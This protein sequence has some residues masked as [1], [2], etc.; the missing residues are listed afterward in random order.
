MTA[1]LWM[2]VGEST[3]VIAFHSAFDILLAAF[4]GL[5]KTKAT[6]QGFTGQL[7]KY[8]SQLREVI[9]PHLRKLTKSKLEK[10]WKIG[11]WI[12]IAADGTREAVARNKEL[13]KTF[14]PSKKN[15]KKRS[16]S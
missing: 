11:K 14:A 9:L 5:K 13:Q 1:V 10:Y 7:A 2:I 15:R 3:I 8:Q 12:V 6:Y 16:R 4:S